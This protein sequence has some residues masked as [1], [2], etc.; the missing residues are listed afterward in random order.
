MAIIA[1]EERKIKLESN[2]LDDDQHRLKDI[3]SAEEVL[4][5]EMQSLED[6]KANIQESMNAKIRTLEGFDAE[7]RKLAT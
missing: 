6:E 5:H 2:S 3:E 1:E 7:L 4:V